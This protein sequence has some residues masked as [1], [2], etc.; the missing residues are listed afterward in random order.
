M[1]TVT[2]VLELEDEKFNKMESILLADGYKNCKENWTEESW[3]R[4]VIETYEDTES[5]LDCNGGDLKSAYKDMI[6]DC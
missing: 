3:T 4:F 5:Y 2:I 1:R 6:Y